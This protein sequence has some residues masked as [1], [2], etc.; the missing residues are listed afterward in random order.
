MREDPFGGP[1]GDLLGD[2]F[3]PLDDPLSA[4]HA[5]L[6]GAT[7]VREVTLAV[8]ESAV[9]T[10]PG[11]TAASVTLRRGG[12]AATVGTSDARALR[13]DEAE[14]AAGEG[15]C[16]SAADDE[17]TVVVP[18]IRQEVRWPAWTEAARRE[19]FLGAA[20]FPVVSDGDVAVSLNTYCDEPVSWLD[21]TV[22]L[23]QRFAVQV[24]R[25]VGWSLK[26]VD[27]ASTTSDLRA[28]L[29]SRAVIDQAV[30]VLM[31]QNRCSPQEALAMLR[32]AS[33]RD[34]VKLRDLARDLVHRV[35][36][37][38]PTTSFVPGG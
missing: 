25:V 18:D 2:R 27:L 21:A 6:L 1:A 26:V 19:G 17:L 4:L 13:C 8:A 11:V 37:T 16:L 30:G 24:A 10:L 23:G 20:A 34:N 7:D 28:A 9:A 5:E 31:A 22:V 38:D 12:R 35:S 14:Y 33:Q 32:R 15:P 29:E 3:D 36:G